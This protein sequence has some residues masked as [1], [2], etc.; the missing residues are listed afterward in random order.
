MST[1]TTLNQ[2]HSLSRPVTEQYVCSALSAFSYSFCISLHSQGYLQ[3]HSIRKVG[4]GQFS[5]SLS[6]LRLKW[7]PQRVPFG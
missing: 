3:L 6:E 1:I 5:V 7:K 4:H 2:R